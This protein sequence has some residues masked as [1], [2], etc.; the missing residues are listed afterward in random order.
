MISFLKKRSEKTE[1]DST[2]EY[3]FL[4]RFFF[5]GNVSDTG[6]NETTSSINKDTGTAGSK[7]AIIANRGLI[8]ASKQ[9]CP[10]FSGSGKR[11]VA[12]PLKRNVRS[13]VW[14]ETVLILLGCNIL[15]HKKHFDYFTNYKLQCYCSI[16]FLYY[17]CSV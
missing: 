1:I 15:F 17:D 16:S 8:D 14:W 10:T 13:L 3:W 5:T 2:R 12:D 6:S 9:R 11:N 7:N 4:F